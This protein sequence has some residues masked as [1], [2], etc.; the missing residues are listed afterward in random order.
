M[1]REFELK[2]KLT[3]AAY[4]A[5]RDRFSG[6]SS[7]TMETV[8]YDTPGRALGKLRWTLRRRL[9]NGSPVCT[10]KTSALGG[11]RGEWEVNCPDIGA[12]IP[13][14][15]AAGAPGELKALTECGVEPICGAR[16]TRLA[17]KVTYEDAVIELALDRGVLTGGGREIPLLELE[18]ELKAGSEAA[19]LRFGAELAERFGLREETKSKFARA[20]EL[21][22]HG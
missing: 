10:M 4:D 20:R 16:F 12:S 15:I 11:S 3:E 5:V 14:L 21:T 8:Y 2:Y 18:A 19:V 1:G 17:A 6:F 22:S 13:L 7:I 9:E